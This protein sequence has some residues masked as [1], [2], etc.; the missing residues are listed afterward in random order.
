M[1]VTQRGMA[2]MRARTLPKREA[3]EE[4]RPISGA[5]SG[6][7]SA[8][9]VTDRTRRGSRQNSKDKKG[10]PASSIRR[11]RAKH[12]QELAPAA[13]IRPP[14]G[15][16]LSVLGN[17]SIGAGEDGAELERVMDE[18]S[19]LSGASC[20]SRPKDLRHNKDEAIGED[21]VF[22]C[23]DRDVAENRKSRTTGG[24]RCRNA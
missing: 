5:E 18:G 6:M 2:K 20:G 7:D 3:A 4:P 12:E 8:R 1:S 22:P 10:T 23:P 14:N 19:I 11:G 24:E 9:D 17:I 15:P 21:A 13:Q 16:G